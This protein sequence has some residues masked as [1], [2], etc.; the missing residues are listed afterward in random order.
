MVKIFA[1]LDLAQ[2]FS[3]MDGHHLVNEHFEPHFNPSISKLSS[4]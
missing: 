2:I 1:F 3:F 4:F